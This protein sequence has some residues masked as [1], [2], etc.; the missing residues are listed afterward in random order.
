[1]VSGQKEKE[2]CGVSGDIGRKTPQWVLFLVFLLKRGSEDNCVSSRVLLNDR[3]AEG[4]A[5]FPVMSLL[6]LS[7]SLFLCFFRKALQPADNRN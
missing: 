5:R 6:W 3:E 2:S 1:M 4:M 7:L